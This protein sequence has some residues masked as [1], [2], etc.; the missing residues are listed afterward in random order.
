LHALGVGSGDYPVKCSFVENK[1]AWAC[2]D[3][4]TAAK[5]AER[6]TIDLKDISASR[7]HAP[8]KFKLKAINKLK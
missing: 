1:R 5:N 3:S 6:R 8:A 7:A 2:V 4:A